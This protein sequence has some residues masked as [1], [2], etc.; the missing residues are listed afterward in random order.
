LNTSEIA[1]EKCTVFSRRNISV[2]GGVAVLLGVLT[3]TANASSVHGAAFP[4]EIAP[5]TRYIANDAAADRCMGYQN[6]VVL[7]ICVPDYAAK[8][9]TINS[10]YVGG[11]WYYQYA[12]ESGYCLGVQGGSSS[13]GAKLAFGSC[14][15]TSDHSQFW[16]KINDSGGH[17]MFKNGHSGLCAGLKGSDTRYDTPIVQG[18]C[19]T[20][21]KTQHWHA[22]SGE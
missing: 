1:K 17:W 5:T 22:S 3:G 2:A 21:S 19:D 6:P 12:N 9:H 4:T 16:A 13:G 14:S 11:M 20:G 10:A 8:V 7:K 15:G 18:T